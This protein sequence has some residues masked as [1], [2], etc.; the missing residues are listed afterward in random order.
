[1]DAQGNSLVGLNDNGV[2]VRTILLSIWQNTFEDSELLGISRNP[3]SSGT[4]DGPYEFIGADS[5]RRLPIINGNFQGARNAINY[6]R[7]G[8]IGN[9]D[10]IDSSFQRRIVIV[11]GSNS[12]LLF[13]LTPPGVSNVVRP[14]VASERN[15]MLAAINSV[16]FVDAVVT[17]DPIAVT[18]TQVEGD[19]LVIEFTNNPGVTDF[20]IQGS[21]DLADDD[22]QDLTA[23]AQITETSQGTYRA[24]IDLSGM[25]SRMFFWISR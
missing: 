22:P 25:D 15:N 8:T 23:L 4:P 12:E 1:M 10:G 19:S 21:P 2:P 20:I 13:S 24:V 17:V 9:S 6:F 7:L 18:G 14:Q 16:D 3:N 11:N 5:D